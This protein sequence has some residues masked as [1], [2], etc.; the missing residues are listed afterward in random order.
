MHLLH[1]RGSHSVFSV[2][3]TEIF[4]FEVLSEPAA[5]HTLLSHLSYGFHSGANVGEISYIEAANK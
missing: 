3:F 1:P 2:V 4:L 5:K